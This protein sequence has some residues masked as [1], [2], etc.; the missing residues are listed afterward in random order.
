MQQALIGGQVIYPWVDEDWVPRPERKAA[1]L[2]LV[3]RIGAEPD[4]A[5]YLSIDLGG[6]LVIAGDS[7]GLKAFEDA[8]EP[9]Q[10]RFPLRLG[11]HAAFHTPLQEP[12]AAQGR[13][14]IRA[15]LFGQP[16][17]PLVD[18]AGR[19]WWPGTVD[20]AALHRYT[21][22]Q[23]VV[24]AYDFTRALTVA[25]REFAPDLFIIL[26]PGTTLGGAVAQSLICAG[27]RGMGG[28]DDFQ[29]VQEANPLLAAMGMADQRRLVTRG[30]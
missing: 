9:A 1:L 22:G 18:G 29:R 15:G 25:A 26:G 12:V 8:V 4:K 6:M 27:W 30:G 2:E 17:L 19:I 23:Q 20:P 10:G 7:A 16:Q 14:R 3:A 11:N 5:L 21:L 28:K 13:A 24:A